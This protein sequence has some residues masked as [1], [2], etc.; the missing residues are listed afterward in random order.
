MT[1]RSNLNY[2]IHAEDLQRSLDEA[3]QNSARAPSTNPVHSAQSPFSSASSSP[4]LATSIALHT[5][6]EQKF[7]LLKE[8]S[9]EAFLNWYPSFLNYQNQG[10]SR[11]LPHCMDPPVQHTFMFLLSQFETSTIQTFLSTS[12]ADLY[13]YI[14]QLFQLSTISN[15]RTL[16]SALHMKE[17]DK[18]NRQSIDVYIQSVTNLI[19][20]YPTMFKLDHG[21]TTQKNFT[22]VFLDGIYPQTFR[23][24]I[25]D[26]G[27]ENLKS[28]VQAIYGEYI[29]FAHYND[30]LAS[31]SIKITATT[32]GKIADIA[33]SGQSVTK[34]C[35]NCK[36]STHRYAKDCP[37]LCTL[38]PG[39]PT[40]KYF[41]AN[42]CNTYTS[43]KARL[44][45]KGTWRDFKQAN[46]ANIA[47][48]TPAPLPSAAHAD[49]AS[50]HQQIA[51]LTTLFK[52]VVS[53]K[54][55]LIDSGCNTTIIASPSHSD[56][57]IIYRDSKEGISTANGQII[58]ILGQGSILQMPADFV[59]TFVDSLISV[60]QATNLNNSCFIF[61]K[62]VAFNICLNPSIVNL[63]NQIHAL[64]VEQKLILCT[65]KLTT[66]NLYAVNATTTDTTTSPLFAAATYYQTAKFDTVAEIVRYFHETWSHCSMDL[67]IQIIKNNIF[68]N[69][70]P[71][72]TE[73]AV[74]K[75]FPVCPACTSGNMT[76]KSYSSESI[77]K[78]D[79][80]PGEELV[81]DIKIIADNK[82]NI[83]KK[84][85][86][87]NVSALTIIDN[88]TNYKWGFPLQ[89]HGTSA[90]ILEKLDI[91]H[92]E[93]LS[94]HR[95][96]KFI[97]ADDQF[98][99]ADIQTWC[100]NMTPQIKLLPCIPHE[101]Q[102]IGKVE[103][104][105]QTWEST[106]IKLL[107]NKPHL[108]HKYWALAY[109]DVIMKSNLLPMINSVTTHLISYGI[110]QLLL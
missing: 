23:Q 100:N 38:C 5:P 20:K 3:L 69:L 14:D 65:A 36:F 85:F 60:S 105:N 86:N 44:V 71:N 77:L 19:T 59:P 66:D 97:R 61:L 82:Y 52:N 12:S 17:S 67:M 78:R 89:N 7:V 21:G 2:S 80:L 35:P 18:F 62:D 42:I 102:Q 34:Q 29:K 46:N 31:S 73:T 92:K 110:T 83:S 72:L 90:T 25:K 79:L 98:V 49:L 76:R 101:H 1:T 47:P 48:A 93:L 16:V 15:Y 63:L 11:T 106:V 109:N 91:V 28:A 68:T 32:E 24:A 99:T 95:V 81:M 104:F 57:S 54:R 51:N 94:Q 4:N 22:I 33:I 75:Y 37:L 43:W 9:K 96:L 70:P 103:R 13:L 50:L 53:K 58:P 56:N 26:R 41:A 30:V 8:C 87:H 45:K 10:G 39:L 84:S 64:A 108:S 55:L 88:A 27:P 40:H 6:L 74:R 107:S